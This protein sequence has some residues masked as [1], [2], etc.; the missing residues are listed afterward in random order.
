MCPATTAPLMQGRWSAPANHRKKHLR[1]FGCL[2]REEGGSPWL[3]T[4]LSAWGSCGGNGAPENKLVKAEGKCHIPG[5]Q[6]LQTACV[7]IPVLLYMYVCILYTDL[8]NAV[9]K[10]VQAPHSR[11]WSLAVAQRAF[12]HGRVS[13]LIFLASFPLFRGSSSAGG[14][15]WAGLCEGAGGGSG[16]QPIK[17]P[18]GRGRDRDGLSREEAAEEEAGGRA[19]HGGYGWEGAPVTEPWGGGKMWVCGDWIL[20]VENWNRGLP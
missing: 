4:P 7:C 10:G 6:A 20:G 2:W 14:G 19:A 1:M 16:A 18:S 17:R 3:L 12:F 5:Q 11:L 15:G 13:L 8:G 9:T